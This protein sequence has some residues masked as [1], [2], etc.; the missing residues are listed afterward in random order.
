[1][2]HLYAIGLG[3]NRRHGRHGAP[4]A[5]LAAALDALAADVDIVACSA[6]IDT[7]PLGP[8]T[9]R[10]ANAAAIIA[11]DLEPPGLLLRVKR[12]ERAFGR[13]RGRRWGDRVLDIDLLLW[14]GGRWRSPALSI[15]HA[16]LAR[17]AFVLVPM[18][19]IAAHWPV[20]AD[21]RAVRHLHSRLTRA[22]PAHNAAHR[23]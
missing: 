4:R 11:S 6:I 2:R 1:M 19:A 16:E 21:A 3:G 13:R 23:V 22:R 8:G 12:L 20:A 10:F 9:R 17:R 5:V 15:P 7:A 18:L 14:S